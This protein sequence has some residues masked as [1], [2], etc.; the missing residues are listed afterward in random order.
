MFYGSFLFLNL[1]LLF[2]G[3]FR[4][5]MLFWESSDCLASEIRNSQEEFWTVAIHY[6]FI[7]WKLEWWNWGSCNIFSPFLESNVSVEEK[8]KFRVGEVMA[9]WIW[10]NQAWNGGNISAEREE[11]RSVFPCWFLDPASYI[12]SFCWFFVLTNA[13]CLLL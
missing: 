8:V 10:V 4:H 9:M 11:L 5:G 7:I 1:L 6:F 2:W 12:A 13:F 3:F